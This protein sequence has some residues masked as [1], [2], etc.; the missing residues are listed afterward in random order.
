MAE[1][2]TKKT[3]IL[4][5]LKDAVID[6]YNHIGYTMLISVL[7]FFTILPLGVFLLNTLRVYF[8]NQDN[9][10]GLLLFLL[11]LAV[12]YTA[13]IIGPVHT[14]LFYQMSRVIENEAEFK[15]LWLG[16][17]KFYWK[18]AGIYALYM[19]TLLFTLVDI[20][21]CFFIAEHILIKFVGFFLVYM[22]LF[23]LLAGTYLPG[24]IVLQDNT[25]KKV[26]KKTLLLTLDNTLATLGIQLILLALGIGCTVVTPLVICFYGGFLQ[27]TGVRLFQG[28][29]SKY[30][31]PVSADDTTSVG[32]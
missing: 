2:N 13:F 1:K 14:A 3:N 8:A 31:D 23:L 26:Y 5:I 19:I 32:E 21:I 25:W 4:F 29:M 24:F 16:L 15:G 30:P 12:P 9:P 28:L 22:F 20:L 6:L 11:L 7:W 10:L 27:I 17:R 18:S